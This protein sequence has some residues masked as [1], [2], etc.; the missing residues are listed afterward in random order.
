M[1]RMFMITP[2]LVQPQEAGIASADTA[3]RP[4]AFSTEPG[5]VDSNASSVSR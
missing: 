4:G 2:R 1:E 5:A 3:I